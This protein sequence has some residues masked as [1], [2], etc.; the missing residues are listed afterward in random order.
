MPRCGHSHAD[1]I[2]GL[3]KIGQVREHLRA[4]PP[5]DGAGPVTILIRHTDKR[6]IGQCGIQPRMVLSQMSDTDNSG[7]K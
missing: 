5:G 1:D 3:Q 6:G 4:V 7:T 2:D